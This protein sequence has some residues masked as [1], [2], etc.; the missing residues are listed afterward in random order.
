[1]FA[2]EL[3]GNPAK[4]RADEAK[5]RRLRAKRE[6]EAKDARRKKDAER[7]DAV[8]AAMCDVNSEP[9]PVGTADSN[10]LNAPQNL[11]GAVSTVAD[12]KVASTSDTPLTAAQIAAEQRK[13]RSEG[14]QKNSSA[15]VIQ[16]LLRSKFVASKTRDE[17]RVVFDKRMSDLIAL[18]GILKK[19][20]GSDYVPPPATASMLVVQFL[21][22]AWPYNSQKKNSD[23][24]DSVVILSEQDV[25][26]WAKLIRHIVLPGIVTDDSD[27]DPLMP[28]LDTLAGERR[29]T[30]LLGLCVSSIA[31]RHGG[32][33]ITDKAAL[34]TDVD[35]VLRRILLLDDS[36]TKY[37]GGAR[38]EIHQISRR[39]FFQNQ[40]AGVAN[41]RSSCDIIQSLRLML[42]YG[43]NGRTS[44]IPAEAGQLRENCIGQ[45]E[46]ERISILFA[47]A[48]DYLAR[49]I[50]NGERDV[51]IYCV[52]FLKE[53]L[54]IP[55]LTWKVKPEAYMRIIDQSSGHRHPPLVGYIQCFI[56]LKCEEV[57][58]GC[59]DVALEMTD[60]SLTSCPAPAVLCLLANLI[61]LGK[62]CSSLNGSDQSKLHFKAA[63]EYHNFLSN[64]I[65][66]APLGTF[67]RRMSA[68]EWVYIGSSSTP[69]VLSEA[70]VEQASSL[71]ADS[72]VR[73]LFRCAIDP[74][75]LDTD[76]VINT[77]SDKDK[78]Y[79]K[80]LEEIGTESVS[81]LAAKE[82]MVDRNRSFWQGSWAKKLTQSVNALITGPD[83]QK[84]RSSLKGP[85]QLMNT[86]S[87]ARQLA[88]GKGS[89]TRTVTNA[90]LTSEAESGNKETASSTKREHEYSI[91][92]LLSLCRTYS[93]IISRWGGCGKDDLVKRCIQD[94]KKSATSSKGSDDAAGTLE[95]CVTALLNVLCFSTSLLDTTCAIIQS[96][97][98]VIA[99]L[100][101]VID[102]NKRREPIRSLNTRSI[103][104]RNN[105]S[106]GE[107]EG[108]IGAAVLLVFTTCLSHTLMV[109]D[110]VEIHDM[111][112]PLP[113][114]QLRRCILLLKKLLYRAC[115]LDDVHELSINLVSDHL[116]LSL[117]SRSSKVMND[118]YSRSSRRLLC[119]PQ[120]WTE[121]SL[122]ESDLRRCK[123]H[124]DYI[125]LLSSPVCRICPFLVSFKRRLKLF[126]RIV[127]TNRIDI[128]GSN[129]FRNLKPGIMV[130]VMRGRVL[131]DGLIH[132]NNLGR[133][134]RQRIVVNYLTQ[135]GTKESGIDVGGL[136]KEFWTDLS[137]IAFD[138]NYALFRVTEG[139]ASLMYPNPS[140]RLAHGSDHIILF[141]FLGRI[142]GKALYEGITIQ[143]QFA[144]LFLSFLKGGHQYLHLLTD[145]ST[146]DPQ[147]Y[148]NLMFLK[149]YTGD[150][151]DLCLTFTVANDDFRVSEVPLIANGANIEVTN[152][153]KRRYIYLVAK[154][155]VCDRI[156]EQSDAFTRGLWEV[157]DRSWLRL[158][159]EP[160]LQV[161]IS[162]PSDGKID[163][164]DMKSNARYT[165]GYSMVDRNII[166]FWSCVS[167]FTPKQQADLLRFVTSC[168]RPP[169]LGF[170]SMNPPFTIQRVGIMRDG[171]KLPTAS[172]CFNTLKLPTYSSEK[173]M[174]ERLL[175]AIQAGAGFELT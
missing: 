12:K 28:W 90:V 134:M 87:I 1:M 98:K 10:G 47:L 14:R 71:L 45:D 123:S 19:S 80:D 126:E 30:K 166:R 37:G 106:L 5:A 55:L 120:F 78:S 86:S 67:S 50:A 18:A 159:N 85:G 6:K 75:S 107:C 22:F 139:S 143:P 151:S 129:D 88:N 175:Y 99:D 137:N 131:E 164:S 42:L 58:N 122:L 60:V 77:K 148:N 65:N 174:K 43:S 116:G 7:M 138:P 109:T 150:V 2:E 62:Q 49:L 92:F 26:R 168:E 25:S 162:G 38:D 89:V 27:L 157:I 145:L 104:N 61:Q 165:G 97:P 161:L 8:A 83:K 115:C 81:S 68:V 108:N 52:R 95:P 160:E 96:N 20:Q 54:A 105:R 15:I 110:D 72:Y 41:E 121:D 16:S 141:E 36:T 147:L 102:V 142:L 40:L 163:V 21:F 133:N 144:H 130:K 124:G 155:H 32:A 169:P 135:A 170:A 156:K 113:K 13:I 82:A 51:S 127:T 152:E 11:V 149:S 69:I 128:Q 34:F 56:D 158:F 125:R 17:Q 74:D 132:L 4:K 136:F 118:L 33:G 140:S 103:Y 91:T 111:E 171:E 31:K 44:P 112:K 73:Q 76:K 48:V 3:A 46:K 23:I 24:Q 35:S 9:K 59:I 117:I 79:E 119:T 84:S 29:L 172:T 39:L 66:A 93:T 100:Y 94:T 173:V 57:S 63:A 146:I 64:L 167:S 153:N 53:V 154:H 101:S 114:H 70:V